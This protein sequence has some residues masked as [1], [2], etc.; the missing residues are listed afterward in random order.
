M[1]IT[2]TVAL[3]S[4]NA[5]LFAQILSFLI[6]LFIINRIMFRPLRD[7]MAK[8]DQTIEG[9]QQEI[10]N[11]DAE[12]TQIFA[13]LEAEEQEVKKEAIAIRKGLE[14]DGK[15][16]VDKI[17]K[18]TD[19][20]IEKLRNQSKEEVQSQILDVRQHLSEESEKIARV[21]MEKALNRRLAYE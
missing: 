16:V 4:I 17:F 19:S 11:A 14:K 9:M 13:T 2:S 12:I 20:E 7:I 15:K 10:G 6:F 21:I 5:T 8:R 3:I 18:D 1:E